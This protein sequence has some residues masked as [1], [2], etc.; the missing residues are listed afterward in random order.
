VNDGNEKRDFTMTEEDEWMISFLDDH[1]RLVRG[2]TKHHDPTTEH[3]IKLLE[4]SM[5]W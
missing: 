3:A 2:S 5:R 1:M 4:E